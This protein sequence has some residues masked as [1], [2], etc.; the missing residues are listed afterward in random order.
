VPLVA[1]ARQNVVLETRGAL[2]LCWAKEEKL[3]VSLLICYLL[4][5]YS[6]QSQPS[7]HQIQP[8]RWASGYVGLGTVGSDRAGL[9]L[10]FRRGWSLV[11]QHHVTKGCH[12]WTHATTAPSDC[13]TTTLMLPQAQDSA[14]PQSPPQW[15]VQRS[16]VWMPAPLLASVVVQQGPARQKQRWGHKSAC[17]GTRSI[18]GGVASGIEGHVLISDM[19]TRLGHLQFLLV[20]QLLLQ[21]LEL[22]LRCILILASP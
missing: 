16:G 22:L 21:R 11:H 10:S 18:T 7:L 17:I 4:L 3:H 15:Q 14:L 5:L 12:M 1:V 8:G 6:T 9:L 2:S 19:A 20:C 13:S